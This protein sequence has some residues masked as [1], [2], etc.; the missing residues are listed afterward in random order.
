MDALSRRLLTLRDIYGGA[1]LKWKIAE[2]ERKERRAGLRQDFIEATGKAG[3]RTERTKADKV[4]ES[5]LAK[6]WLLNLSSMRE[7]LGLCFGLD[8]ERV[9]SLVDAGAHGLEYLRGREPATRRRN[10][11]AVYRDGR[12]SHKGRTG[13]A[14]ISRNAP[15]RPAKE[16]SQPS[17][18]IQALLMWRREDGRRH[19][20]GTRDESGKVV[21]V[22]V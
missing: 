11:G 17:E 10:R 22:V 9:T 8:N 6:A 14:G 4:N 12:D 21:V 7:V 20:E 15:S 16:N 1:W 13:S 18:T 19:M 5:L 3:V 2:I